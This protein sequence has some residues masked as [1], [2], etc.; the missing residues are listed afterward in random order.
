MLRP[1]RCEVVVAFS[2]V[3]VPFALRA[4]KLERKVRLACITLVHRVFEAARFY[5]DIGRQKQ[6]IAKHLCL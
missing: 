5:V 4:E 6:N 1:L 2:L 3:T